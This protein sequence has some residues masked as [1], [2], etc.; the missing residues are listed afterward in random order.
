MIWVTGRDLNACCTTN[1]KGSTAWVIQMTTAR[2]KLTSKGTL[3]ESSG[4]LKFVMASCLLTALVFWPY[5]FGQLAVVWEP[6]VVTD[7]G[8]VQKIYF[9]G[10]LGFSTQIDTETRTFLAL[11]IVN[12]PKGTPLQT[13][14]DYFGRRVCVANTKRCWEASRK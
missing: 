8:T 7:V 2:A 11:D 3:V 13:R 9:V 10:W 4:S 14:Q 12:L 5:T 1:F 6:E